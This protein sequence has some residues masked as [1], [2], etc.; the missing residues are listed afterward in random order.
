[1][2]V[3]IGFLVLIGC[4]LL[5]ITTKEKNPWKT[6][7]TDPDPDFTGFGKMNKYDAYQKCIKIVNSCRTYRQ[8]LHAIQMS[9]LHFEMYHDS[10]LSGAIN[11]EWTHAEPNEENII[12]NEHYDNEDRD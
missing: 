11:I 5:Y 9:H 3:F 10:F 1:M 7:D 12:E 6:E 8:W 2:F 4:I